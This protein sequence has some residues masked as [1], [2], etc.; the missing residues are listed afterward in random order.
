MVTEHANVAN[1]FRLAQWKIAG[2]QY[3]AEAHSQFVNRILAEFTPEFFAGAADFGLQSERPVFL[4]GLPRSGTTLVEQILACHSQVFAAGE[5][6]L[7]RD[8]YVATCQNGKD[9]G[10]G[11]SGLDREGI[12]RLAGRHLDE[13]ERRNATALRVVDKMPDNYLYLGFLAALFPRAVHSL[14]T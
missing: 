7:A 9:R 5:L 12:R 8:A 1:A 2:E 6:P 10:T 14:P 11:N 13:L 4:V 3:D